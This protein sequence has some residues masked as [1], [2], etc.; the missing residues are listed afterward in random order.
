VDFTRKFAHPRRTGHCDISNDRTRFLRRYPWYHWV[1]IA[2]ALVIAI[3]RKQTLLGVTG[4][5][6]SCFQEIWIKIILHDGI[7]IVKRP[8][9]ALD[10]SIELLQIYL[11]ISFGPAVSREDFVLNK[12]GR[13]RRL[14]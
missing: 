13:A 6:L 14:R 9:V 11:K 5:C 1:R 10:I 4:A 12:F 8:F 2:Q 7:W 3:R